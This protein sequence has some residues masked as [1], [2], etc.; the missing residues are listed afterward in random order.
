MSFSELL[1]IA[2]HVSKEMIEKAIVPKLQTSD[3]RW[4]DIAHGIVSMGFYPDPD[5]L[6]RCSPIVAHGGVSAVLPGEI[7]DIWQ[8]Y[9]CFP[10]LQIQ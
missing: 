2:I 1:I 5:S 6:F 10:Q 8:R 3:K 7:F 4:I 9:T